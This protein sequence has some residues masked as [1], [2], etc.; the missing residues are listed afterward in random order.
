LINLLSQLRTWF[1]FCEEFYD[2]YLLKKNQGRK[3]RNNVLFITI[4][5]SFFVVSSLHKK[6]YFYLQAE[7]L[8]PA[9]ASP[10]Y[11]T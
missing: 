8:Q 4:S 7:D 5:L 1:R 2:Y 3:S 10:Q 9:E 6:F 11:S